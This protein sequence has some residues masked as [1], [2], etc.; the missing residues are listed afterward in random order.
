MYL[1]HIRHAI[2]APANSD[3][4]DKSVSPNLY[5]PPPSRESV[6]TPPGG[7]EGGGALP[8]GGSG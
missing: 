5:P 1:K 8:W 4:S 3:K 7:G 6:T 2:T